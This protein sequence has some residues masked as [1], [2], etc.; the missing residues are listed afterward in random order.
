MVLWDPRKDTPGLPVPRFRCGSI[1]VGS[2]R[3]CLANG[4]LG[5]HGLSNDNRRGTHRKTLVHR[6]F[7]VRDCERDAAGFAGTCAST[8]ILTMVG[9]GRAVFSK[10][11][12]R[13]RDL[14]NDNRR[15]SSETSWVRER[16]ADAILGFA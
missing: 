3:G 16:G 13:C 5:Y 1:D 9:P 15:K 12:V 11:R 6:H 10:G 8:G 7:W 2:G 4:P 14:S